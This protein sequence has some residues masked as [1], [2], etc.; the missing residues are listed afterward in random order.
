M[1]MSFTA[2]THP[3]KLGTKFEGKAHGSDDPSTG[4]V[5]PTACWVTPLKVVKYPPMSTRVSSGATA[6][7]VTDPFTAGAH[8]STAPVAAV[9]APTRFRVTP[10]SFWKSPPR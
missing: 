10:P 6:T 5:D 1:T 8:G 4:F 3:L 7:D 9:T 2:E